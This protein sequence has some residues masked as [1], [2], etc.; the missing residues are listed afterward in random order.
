MKTPAFLL[1]L[2]PA[3]LCLS[4][5]ACASNPRTVARESYAYQGAQTVARGPA[6]T[7][8]EDLRALRSGRERTTTTSS[9][10][11][12]VNRSGQVKAQSSDTEVI[13]TITETV[14]E[15]TPV[16]SGDAGF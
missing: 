6:P 14:V 16:A 8:D 2:V 10:S 11:A 15:R 4:L 12:Q 1:R 9:S 7:S 13:D 3:A 5:V